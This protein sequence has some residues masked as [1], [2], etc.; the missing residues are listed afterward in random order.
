MGS[1]RY[2]LENLKTQIELEVARPVNDEGSGGTP[3]AVDV[4]IGDEKKSLLP[5]EN[6]RVVL[7]LHEDGDDAIAPCKEL[8]P[9]LRALCTWQPT[10]SA[11]LWVPVGPAGERTYLGRLDAIEALGRCVI[12]SLHEKFHGAN[13]TNAQIAEGATVVRSPTHLRHGEAAIVLFTVGAPI[14]KGRT[15]TTLSPGSRLAVTLNVN[16][17]S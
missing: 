17:E 7:S 2:I 10:F 6:G 8:N 13:A 12:R 14:T 11:R 3:F 5:G 4:L 15:L 16:P 1:F 9:K